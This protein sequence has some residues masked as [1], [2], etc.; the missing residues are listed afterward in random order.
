[1]RGIS[2]INNSKM[3]CV[4]KAIKARETASQKTNKYQWIHKNPWI[5]LHSMFIN[6]SH[7]PEL[8]NRAQWSRREALNNGLSCWKGAFLKWKYLQIW[9]VMPP[10]GSFYLWICPYVCRWMQKESDKKEERETRTKEEETAN[11]WVA[12]LSL[13]PS[14]PPPTVPLTTWSRYAYKSISKKLR[15]LGFG[16]G[17]N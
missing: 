4:T 3:N 13:S 10:H 8:L 7:T 11:A 9:N 12:I 2:H 5:F 15:W 6:S 17:N 16:G 1:M 14:H